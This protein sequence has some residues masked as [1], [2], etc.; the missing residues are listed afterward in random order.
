MNKYHTKSR[1]LFGVILLENC[2]IN[3]LQQDNFKPIRRKIE[4]SASVYPNRVRLAVGFT[5]HH[6][7]FLQGLGTICTRYDKI[8]NPRIYLLTNK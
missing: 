5:F 7:A 3:Y 8:I 6:L 2:F 1:F 4:P